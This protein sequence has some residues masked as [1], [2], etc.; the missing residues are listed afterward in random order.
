MT[1]GFGE[2]DTSWTQRMFGTI[3]LAVILFKTKP[4]KV[5]NF[6]RVGL[7]KLFYYLFENA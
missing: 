2:H 6:D 3:T 7:N 1:I 4:I 5:A